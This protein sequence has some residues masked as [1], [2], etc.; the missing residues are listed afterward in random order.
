L[1]WPNLDAPG[2]T[3]LPA[4]LAECD[5]VLMSIGPKI[6]VLKA[7]GWPAEM[8]GAVP[9]R[10]A[11]R[12]PGTAGATGAGRRRWATKWRRSRR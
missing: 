1:P 7:I 10:L 6:K 4:D 3:E 9:R 11:A 5:R 8:E 2:G 12:R